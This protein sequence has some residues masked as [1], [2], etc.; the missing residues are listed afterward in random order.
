MIGCM[1]R[2]A[3]RVMFLGTVACAPP[4]TSPARPAPEARTQP[5]FLVVYRRGPAWIPGKPVTDQPLKDHF[6]F[7]LALYKQGVLQLAGPFTDDTGGA[8]A[9]R[10]E[11]ED[12][13]RAIVAADPAVTSGVMI[14]ELH[15]WKLVS[16]EA[17]IKK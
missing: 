6:R 12:A 15:A 9:L 16:W 8:A 1:C 11:T 13:A 17:F 2:F 5:N 4:A 7:L 14:P 10:V 3:V